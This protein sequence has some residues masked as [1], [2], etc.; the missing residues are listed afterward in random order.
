MNAYYI[1]SGLCPKTG[2]NPQDVKT[3]CREA[4]VLAAELTG[5]SQLVA[6]LFAPVFGF[7][8]DRYRRF[9]IPLLMAALTGLLGYI[10]LA[11]M[12]S[13]QAEEAHGIPW[14]FVIMALLGISQIGAIVCSLGLLGRGVLGLQAESELSGP[15]S[16]DLVA[17]ADAHNSNSNDTAGSTGFA[18]EDN[19]E[20]AAEGTPLLRG[21]D[22]SHSHLKGSIAGVYSL[23]GG[24]GILLLTKVGGLLFDKVSPVA[25]FIMVSAFNLLLLTAGIAIGISAV[26]TGK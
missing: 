8:A 6:L 12:A 5:V 9:N 16:S 23:A 17:R 25:P 18:D 2:H 19:T 21:R 14:I 4:Y 15:I 10:G 22:R 24:V 3:S 26:W 1:S 13:P 20:E 11:I 7:L